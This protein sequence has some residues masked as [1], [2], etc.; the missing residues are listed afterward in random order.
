MKITPYT[1]MAVLMDTG[2]ER[3]IHPANKQ[4]AGERLALLAL[5]NTYQL[6]GFAAESPTYKEITIQ[7]DTVIVSFDGAPLSLTA[8]QM[9][10]GLFTVAGND[11]VFYT[12]KAWISGSKVFV[13]SDAVKEPV[14]VRYA[15][16]N[17]VVGDLFS[18]EGLPVSSFRSDNW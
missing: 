11:R 5:K 6:P 17:Y 13:K 18:T 8:P 2:E 12:A 9:R 4:L 10:S 16:E 3:N 1:G 15:F 7:N 14:A